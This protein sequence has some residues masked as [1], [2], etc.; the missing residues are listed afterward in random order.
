MGPMTR[1]EVERALSEAIREEQIAFD[2]ARYGRTE[3]REKHHY[4]L[5]K[6]IASRLALEHSTFHQ[7]HQA[8]DHA[9]PTASA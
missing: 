8:Q 4:A 3:E 9:K 6:V 5:Q 2:N 7:E 1:H